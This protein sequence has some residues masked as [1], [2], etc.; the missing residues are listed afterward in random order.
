VELVFLDVESSEVVPS[1]SD[2]ILQSLQTLEHRA[3]I[4]AVSLRGISVGLEQGVVGFESSE[5][6]FS[7][8]LHDDDH[9]GGH[10]EGAV[11][12]LVRLLGGAVVK[13]PV[14][15]IVFVL[16]Q[17]SQLPGI[18][19]DHSQVEW[20]EVF[21]EGVVDQVVVDVKEKGIAVVLRGVAVGDP[22]EFVCGNENQE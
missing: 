16:E 15:H 13:H 11:D 3:L 20:A 18:P 9:E 4:F 14:V 22:V 19:V 2:G 5:G 7:S 6:L 10:E 21:V 1:E 8:T 17:S 12:Q